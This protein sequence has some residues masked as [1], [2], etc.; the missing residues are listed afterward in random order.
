MMMATGLCIVELFSF[1][2]NSHCKMKSGGIMKSIEGRELPLLTDTATTTTEMH[3]PMPR[4]LAMKEDY[5]DNDV[6][7]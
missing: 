2:E 5:D 1:I 4:S 7:W 3:A 6:S